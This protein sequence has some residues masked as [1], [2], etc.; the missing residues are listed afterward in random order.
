[1]ATHIGV[2]AISSLDTYPTSTES[3]Q[4]IASTTR[5]PWYLWCIA[6]A[7]TCNTVGIPWDISWHRTIGRD[8]F[9]NPAH[10]TIYLS[11][12]FAI[13]ACSYLILPTTFRRNSPFRPFSVRVLGLRGPLGAFVAAWGGIAMLTSA[14]FDD[15]WHNAYGLDVR[16]VSPPHT[17][18][19]F[20]LRG[21]SIGSILL[22]ATYVN[23]AAS[24]GD[25]AAY[26][27]G[28]R[29]LL[30]LGTL[31]VID[32]SIFLIDFDSF[33]KWH[34]RSPY[35]TIA[36]TIFP[37][38]AM[39]AGSLRHRWTATILT[40]GYMLFNIAEI[41][42]LPLF[43]AQPRLGPVYN[44]VTHMIPMEFPI[45][46]IVVGVAIDLVRQR[47]AGWPSLTDTFIAS[48]LSIASLAAVSWP[49]ANFL[50]SPAARNRFFGTMYQSYFARP[51]RILHPRFDLPEH[52]LQFFVSLLIAVLFGTATLWI[53]A[54]LG[55]WVQGL[56][57]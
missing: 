19:F 55:R 40:G 23:R 11:A 13:L 17:L 56:Q 9:W 49:F 1:M 38:L 20:G 54:R 5:M 6:L 52:G 46:L 43:P 36:L 27:A 12:V 48:T 31:L 2:Q 42:F 22:V 8:S 14:P 33:I 51:E 21:I 39:M 44:P 32:I 28:Q 15:W 41:L 10:V 57:R 53:G 26:R 18:L 25:E 34:S 30:Y 45:L 3:S 37:V 47:F 50:M 7:A 35:T 24:H 16:L 4:Q 29:M